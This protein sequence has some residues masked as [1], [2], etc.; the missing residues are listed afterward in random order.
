[1]RGIDEREE[2]ADRHRLDAGFLERAHLLASLLLVER[3]EHRAVLDDPLG[4]GQPVAPP[5]D[6]VALPR[7]ILVVG[8]VERLLVA[9]D[10]EDVA[11]ALGREQP[12]AG[13]G[14]LD[15]DVRRDR[16][17]MEDLIELRR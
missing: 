1:V 13:T 14:V 15:H 5:H 2:E 12:H 8:E 3:H 10:V 4:H 16:R 11:V 17:S 7:Q 6:W 9:R